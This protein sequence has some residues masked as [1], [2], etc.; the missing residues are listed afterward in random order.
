MI[1]SLPCTFYSFPFQLVNVLTLSSLF[2]F[3]WLVCVLCW[4][5]SFPFVLFCYGP[6]LRRRIMWRVLSVES[7]HR[8]SRL[9][10]WLV[11][12]LSSLRIRRWTLCND[13]RWCG[14]AYGEQGTQWRARESGNIACNNQIYYR[15]GEYANGSQKR[16]ESTQD[17]GNALPEM[18]FTPEN[19]FP[20]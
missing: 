3:Y 9:L 5:W 20:H 11:S 7:Q 17:S 16:R 8:P 4:C 6:D 19:L 15:F 14:T 13:A 2:C 1:F 10:W 18:R 12:D